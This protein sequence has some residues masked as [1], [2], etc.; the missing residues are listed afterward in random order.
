MDRRRFI[1]IGGG[2]G[3]ALLV[4]PLGP[5]AGAATDRPRNPLP[6]IRDPLYRDPIADPAAIPRFENALPRPARI[7]LLKGGA[8]TLRLAATRQDL[9]GG[10]LGLRTPVWGFARGRGPVATPG[11]TIEAYKRRPVRIHWVNALPSRHLLP[12]DTTL[13]WAFSHTGYTIE[14]EG[15]PA[16]MHLHGGHTDARSDG[17][18]DAWYTRTGAVGAHYCG[19]HYHY[20]NS[21]EAAT[22]WYH[23]HALGITRLNIYA[24]LAGFYLLRDPRE[25]NLIDDGRLPDRRHEVELVIQD[26]M[27]Y[28]DGRLAYPD[29]PVDAKGWPGGPTVQ[30]EFF[31]QVI[32]VNGKAWPYLEVEPRQYRL[33]LLNG[34]SSR[35]Y[36]LS[37]GGRW[38]FPMTQIGTD[39]GF[40]Y[41]PHP[42][43]RPLTLAPGERVDLVADFRDSRGETFVLTNDAPTPAPDG[44][45]ATAP[46][47]EILQFRVGRHRYRYDAEPRL[48]RTL[49][50]TQYGVHKPAARTRRLL[51]VDGTD[52]S[53]RVLPQLGTVK[54]GA[55]RWDDPTTEHLAWRTTEIWEIFN[56]TGRTHPVHLHL[57]QF[58]V[59]DRAPFT[60]RRAPKTGALSDVRVGVARP[61]APEERGPKD[62][63]RVP[64]GQVTRVKAYFDRRGLYVWHG[65]ILENKDHEMMRDIMVR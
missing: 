20:D 45:P 24:G 6:A 23:D 34:S 19:T 10:G 40:L 13:H 17:H 28:P 14:N 3:S 29:V 48:P 54:E 49:R 4:P 25:L 1:A 16:V 12:I 15:V 41:R 50:P 64:P 59:L 57:V 33:R 32:L 11:P 53:G 47:T 52:E 21:Q 56:T 63:V 26:R 37:I 22:L 18:P 27:F 62:T 9:L 31:G 51:L 61:P 42:L 46:A 7:N 30:P 60:A 5:A 55:K 35:F 2:L 39:G 65:H 8:R 36:R 38:P 58:E 43:D 44:P